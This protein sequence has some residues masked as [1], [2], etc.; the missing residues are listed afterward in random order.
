MSVTDVAFT[1]LDSQRVGYGCSDGQVGILNLKSKKKDMLAT[2]H[3]GGSPIVATQFNLNDHILASA[4]ADG[5]ISVITFT[6][7]QIKLSML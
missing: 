5:A 6:A 1:N 3:Q 4:F 7:D 2:G